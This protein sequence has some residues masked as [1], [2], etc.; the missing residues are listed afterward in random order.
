MSKLVKATI[1][2]MDAE[3]ETSDEYIAA[4]K[5]LKKWEAD[6]EIVE[7]STGGW[8]HIW[9][10]IGTRQAIEDLPDMISC[11]SDWAGN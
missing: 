9:D 6:V 7:Y 3:D 10:V 11:S 4:K 8:E 1:V 5:W 2:A